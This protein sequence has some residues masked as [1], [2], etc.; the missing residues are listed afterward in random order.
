MS[1]D[2]PILDP[3]V[4]EC[5]RE[6]ADDDE[7]DLLAEMVDLFCADSPPRLD[8]MEEAATLAGVS[9]ARRFLHIVAPLL[10]G[11]LVASFL[12]VFVFAMRDLDS[13]ILVPAANKTAVCRLFNA[14]HFGRQSF[15]AALALMIVFAILLPG[16]LWSLFAKK[17]L[18]ILP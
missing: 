12:L 2:E 4:I 1:Q 7:P 15:I 17:R 18:E 14:M 10:K 11:T 16:L 6:L 9:P 5:L 8:A 3:D 13:A